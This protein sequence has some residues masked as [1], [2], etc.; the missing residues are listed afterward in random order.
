MA[1]TEYEVRT[2]PDGRQVRTMPNGSTQEVGNDPPPFD[3]PRTEAGAAAVRPIGLSEQQLRGQS[4]TRAQRGGIPVL[5]WV[6]WTDGQQRRVHAYAGE[7]TSTAARIR[8]RDEDR[9]WD[10]WTWA[11][12]VTRRGPARGGASSG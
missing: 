11:V 4:V 3:R 7:W 1:S 5:A 8:W 10:L 12:A 2:M 6:P 9:E